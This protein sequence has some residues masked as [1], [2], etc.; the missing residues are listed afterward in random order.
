MPLFYVYAWYRDRACTEIFY[1]GKGTRRRET[2][3]QDMRRD[4]NRH[5]KAI[6]AAVISDLGHVPTKRLRDGLTN[7]EAQQA[8]IELIAAFGRYPG[9]PLANMTDG[10]TGGAL[11]PEAQA[12]RLLTMRGRPAP[13]K[14]KPMSAEQ[15][16]KCEHTFLKPG[17]VP[18]NKGVPTPEEVRAKQ[19]GVPKSPE[20][21]AKM[22][23]AKKGKPSPNKGKPMPP[24]QVEAMRQRM[25]GKKDSEA[26]RR[27]K[28]ESA[29]RTWA[30]SE[31]RT[32]RSVAVTA[33]WSNASERRIAAA[34][35]MKARWALR[36]QPN[37][38]D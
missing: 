7:L 34:A 2:H 25:L 38:T 12:K 19:R 33:Q 24:H 29:S 23:A 8:E 9:G 22:S 17:L 28:A 14:G 13:N 31:A 32:A 26:T 15:R 3:W 1:V 4:R 37:I 5:L 18:W 20:A 36:R 30:S 21:R 27:R 11:T 35:R 16:A 10:G 6:V